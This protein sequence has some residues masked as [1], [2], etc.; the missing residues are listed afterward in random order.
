MP[1]LKIAIAQFGQET[2]SFS[3]TQTT[4]DTFEKFGLYE[5]DAFRNHGFAEGA[6]GGFMETASKINLAWEPIPI[7]R[8]WAGASGPLTDE[9]LAHFVA[10]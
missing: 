8:G 2:S 7:I 6:V 3:S 4:L 9:T 10:N 5:G 1:A